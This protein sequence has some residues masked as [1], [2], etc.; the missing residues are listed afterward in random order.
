MKIYKVQY[1]YAQDISSP[2][3]HRNEEM[4]KGEVAYLLGQWLMKNLDSYW[5]MLEMRG[6]GEH[7]EFSQAAQVLVPEIMQLLAQG[8][9]WTAYE[10]W[11]DFYDR[12][13]N[14]FDFP[15]FVGIGTVIVETTDPHGP[16]PRRRLLKKGDVPPM[17][18]H[19]PEGGRVRYGM[20]EEH[21]AVAALED[22][23]RA[24]AREAEKVGLKVTTDDFNKALNAVT[25]ELAKQF[26]GREESPEAMRDF[27]RR[28]KE[29][30]LRRLF[31][32]SLGYSLGA[33]QSW[34]VQYR[35]FGGIWHP[36]FH[37][38]EERAKLQAAE[39]LEAMAHHLDRNIFAESIVGRNE[40][41]VVHGRNLVDRIRNL[42]A[43]EK[44]W[45]AYRAYK[46]FAEE[47]EDQVGM[48][49]LSMAIGAMRV[50]PAPEPEE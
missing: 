34:L 20:R 4:A 13:E 3:I 32:V 47:W 50:I 41:Y 21:E 45:T 39:Y 28:A 49:P 48:F 5:R 24:A 12:F 46:E 23:M 10:R 16:T 17:I 31:G 19:L 8:D 26:A 30:V 27:Y 22:I 44:V 6:P 40:E 37:T 18:E 9:V 36:S 2:S 33:F 1:G 25:E 7:A 43:D 15:L 38:N 35:D 11:H 14:E 42:L 29:G